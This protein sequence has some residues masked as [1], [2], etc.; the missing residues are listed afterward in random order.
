MMAGWNVDIVTI[1]APIKTGTDDNR[2]SN[3]VFPLLC[4][5]CFINCVGLLACLRTFTF[6]QITREF[7][8]STSNR[9]SGRYSLRNTNIAL[10]P[11]TLFSG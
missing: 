4:I 6:F 7:V 3:T 5:H 11:I 2:L 9:S 10:T 1:Y 8:Q